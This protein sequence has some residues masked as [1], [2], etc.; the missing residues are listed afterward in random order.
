MR[1]VAGHCFWC[2]CLLGLLLVASFVD[3]VGVFRTGL[4]VLL[5]VL[6]WFR[7]CG[8]TCWFLFVLFVV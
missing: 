1:A 7:V 3:N 5:W 6:D 2:Y 4:R 8:D